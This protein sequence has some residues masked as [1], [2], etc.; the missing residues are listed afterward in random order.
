MMS[1]LRLQIHTGFNQGEWKRKGNK[2]Q[3]NSLGSNTKKR[4]KLQADEMVCISTR[5][6]WFLICVYVFS[7]LM[8]IPTL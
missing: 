3:P 6:Q 8:V 1:N 7:A 2:T 4:L 5:T